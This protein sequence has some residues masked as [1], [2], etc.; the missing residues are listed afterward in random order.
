MGSREIESSPQNGSTAKRALLASLLIIA[1]ALRL[2]LSTIPGYEDDTTHFKWW[3]KLVTQVGWTQAYSGTYPET[4]AIYP[5]FML[6]PLKATGHLYER[7]FSPSFTLDDPRL[8]FMIKGVGILFELAIW[9]VLFLWTRKRHSFKAA[10]W[11]VLAYAFSPPLIFDIAYWGE[12]DSIH[13]FFLLA[14][15]VLLI[16]DRPPLSWIS[17]TLAAFTKPQ[18]WVFFP[19]VLILTWWKSGVKRL[20]TGMAAG[21]GV[22]LLLIIPFIYAGTGRG[23]LSLPRQVYGAMPF[24]SANAHNIWWLYSPGP[25]LINDDRMVGFL[26]LHTIGLLLL[27]IF[28]SYAVWRLKAHLAW[29]TILPTAA[30][31]GFIF[32]MLPTRVHENHMFMVFPLLALALPTH[33]H[34]RVIFAVLSLTFLANMALHDPRLAPSLNALVTEPMV[35]SMQTWNS[36]INVLVLGFWAFLLPGGR[37][38]S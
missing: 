13:S 17:L 10:S 12:P 31:V 29:S 36:I 26:S 7:F 14:S 15:M 27:G 28:Y 24:I 18:A 21:L 11:V 22:A 6:L 38:R 35:R 20:I 3:T 1:L 8:G 33:P 2:Y 4:Y 5:P 32:F 19:L 23:L 25:P 16:E 37:G 9:L 30:F 34:L